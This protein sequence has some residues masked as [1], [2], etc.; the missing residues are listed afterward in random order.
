MRFIMTFIWTFILMQMLAYVAGQMLG[1][2]Y[3][4]SVAAIISV[5]ATPVLYLISAVTPKDAPSH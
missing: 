1:T 3:D 5:I 2:G 4:F